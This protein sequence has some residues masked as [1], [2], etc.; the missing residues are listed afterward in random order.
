[1]A[2]VC[3]LIFLMTTATNVLTIIVAAVKAVPTVAAGVGRCLYDYHRHAL[4][5]T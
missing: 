5:I 4:R 3:I 1:M 2:L